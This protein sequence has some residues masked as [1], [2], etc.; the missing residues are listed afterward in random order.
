MRLLSTVQSGGQPSAA[1]IDV[2][3][4]ALNV[5]I[6]S[7]SNDSLMIYKYQPYYFLTQSNKQDYTLGPG[8]D[9][10]TER[11][12]RIQEAY[13]NW[14]TATGGGLQ[15]VSLPISIANDD[16]WSSIVV[17]YIKTQFPTILYDNGN[18]PLRTISLYPI[19]TG[20]T[21]IVLWLWKPLLTFDTIDDEIEFPKGYERCIRYNLAVELAPEYGIEAPIKV[22]ETAMTSKMDLAAVNSVPQFM[23]MDPSMSQRSPTFNWLYGD[24]LP[25]PK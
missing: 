11:S 8:G 21:T 4:K 6:D 12:M 7:W 1:E 10:D 25:I 5:M 2:G 16:Q 14:E 24:T 17:K 23:R 13:V 22:Q 19:P 15:T 9:W 3:L 18:Y 20:V